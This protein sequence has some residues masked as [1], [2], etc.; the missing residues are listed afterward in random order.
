[1]LSLLWVNSSFDKLLVEEAP[2][3]QGSGAG[4]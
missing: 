1:M 3:F 2:S 4:V